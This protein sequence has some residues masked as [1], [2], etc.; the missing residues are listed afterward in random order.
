MNGNYRI[1]IRV[2]PHSTGAGKDADQKAVGDEEQRFI[3]S[4]A[5]FDD[6]VRQSK[7]LARGIEVNPMVWKA[8]IHSIKY[9]GGVRS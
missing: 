3:V 6:A 2:W 8:P 5:D 7:L 4:A 9:I 1:T